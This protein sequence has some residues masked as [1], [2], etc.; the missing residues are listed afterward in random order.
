MCL[1]LEKKEVFLYNGIRVLQRNTT[2]RVDRYRYSYGYK[3]R[4]G[5]RY[6]MDIGIGISIGVDIGTD[7]KK[8]I[9][10]MAHIVMET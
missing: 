1:L 6:D 2:S 8:F 9:I 5:H 10:R 7:I 3:H 4:Y